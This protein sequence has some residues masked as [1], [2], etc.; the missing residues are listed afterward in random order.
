M[1][2]WHNSIYTNTKLSISCGDVNIYI[3]GP[4]PKQNMELKFWLPRASQEVNSKNDTENILEYS[5]R[6]KT[7]T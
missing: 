5:W 1:I 3:E 7:Y 4:P 2:Y 6:Q